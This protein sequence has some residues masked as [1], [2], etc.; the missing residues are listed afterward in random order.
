MPDIPPG[1][2]AALAERYR[3]E[4]ELGAGGMATVYLAQDL[5]HDRPVAI[6]VLRPEL[7]VAIGA[8]RFLREIATTANL[9]H[10]HILPLYDSGEAAGLLFYVMPFV[11]GESLRTRLER[12]RQLPLE[13]ALRISREVADA[14]SYAHARGVIH[15]DIKP[16]NILLEG[17]HAVVADFGIARA[18]DAAGGAQ[19]TETGLAIG[20]PTYMSPE[21]AAGNQDLDGRSDL[22]ALACVLYEMLAGQPP[23]SG[24]TAESLVRQHIMVDAPP[25]TNLRPA[26]PAGVAAALQRALAKTPADRFNPVAQFSEAL[27]GQ[28]A[29][30]A[31]PATA[32]VPPVNGRGVGRWVAV[33]AA[34]IIAAAALAYGLRGSPVDDSG[35]LSSIAV[36]PFTDMSAAGDMEYFGDGMAEE[37]LNALAGLPGL[38]VAGRTSSFSFK[39]KGAD[40]K[41]IG[42]ALGVGTLLEGSVRRSA[43]RIRITAQLIRASDQSH[44]WSETFDRGFDEDV[45]AIQDEIARAIVTALQVQLGGR[46]APSV[47]V[48][49]GTDNLDAYNAYLLGRFQW[50]RRTRDGVL[51]SIASFRQAIRLDPNYARAYTGVA[52]AYAIAGNFGWMAP[53]EAF[54][55][56]RE[57]VDKALA[58]NPELAEA[59]VSLGA[60]LSWY[61]WDFAGADRAFQRALALNP[62]NAFARYWYS[63]L[64]DYTNR[65][66]EARAQI[67]AALRL[68]PLALQIRNGIANRH[69][70]YGDYESAIR[71]YRAILE[72]DP[73]FQNARRWLGVAYLE[74]GQPREG[75]A[76][77]DSVPESFA[78]DVESLRGWGLA[79]LGRTDEARLALRG[80]LP[81]GASSLP[82][83]VRGYS[84]LGEPDEAFRALHGAWDAR[85]YPL[86]QMVLTPASDPLRRDLRFNQLLEDI[87]L[88]KY[89]Q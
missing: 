80:L 46:A 36:L 77:L 51:G 7:A 16:E 58:L 3:I 89:W 65:R 53:R 17:N 11:D 14:L 45:F 79:L 34:V 69:Q 5:K 60:I 88:L 8:E 29:S 24:P 82:Y 30:A 54:P 64:L 33:G 78:G 43:D 62:E 1:L 37:I 21:Q 57:A 2:S 74:A 44:L 28:A 81:R 48:Q 61:E 31:K 18:V 41:S 63:L 84:V 55:Q 56:A 67:E 85:L 38:K 66:E 39:D 35:D 50:N 22:Y 86:L 9:R 73:D 25:V 12:D 32:L 76:V 10:P 42:A 52:D 4:R 49:R 27:H 13:D 6:K 72:I 71:E 83:A 15:R 23:F 40:L 26:V 20:T 47:A 87:G 75:L 70:W 59:H 19:L 68:D